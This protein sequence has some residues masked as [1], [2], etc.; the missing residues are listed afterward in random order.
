MKDP[1]VRQGQIDAFIGLGSNSGAVEAN[2]TEAVGALSDLEG[3]EV[4]QCSAVY[5]TEPQGV[6]DQPWF[7]NQVVR[8][9]CDTDVWEAQSLLR[10][11]HRIEEE[12]GRVRQRRWGQ[13]IIDLDLLFFGELVHTNSQLILPHPRIRERAFVLVPILEIEPELH[14]PDG[15]RLADC[16][17]SLSYSLDGRIIRQDDPYSSAP[18]R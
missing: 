5:S 14:L 10:S 8:V 2:L 15:E 12:M 16:L 4:R 7:G 17:A 11:M 9:R 6:T 1:R 3:L 18:S 13:R